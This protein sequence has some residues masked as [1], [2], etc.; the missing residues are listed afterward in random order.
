MKERGGRSFGPMRL[1]QSN[2]NTD[3]GMK[4]PRR[5]ELYRSRSTAMTT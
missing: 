3:F 5:P 1:N 4:T 2:L